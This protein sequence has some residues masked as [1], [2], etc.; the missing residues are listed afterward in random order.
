MTKTNINDRRRQE[1]VEAYCEN[2]RKIDYTELTE[3]YGLQTVFY[4][5]LPYREMN[6]YP[7]ASDFVS[8][9]GKAYDMA[10]FSK[11]SNEEQKAC[12]L[13]YYCYELDKQRN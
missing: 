9:D 11:L 10:S 2:S 4:D 7:V 5:E 6:G 13:R 8:P 12:R 1:Y 3:E